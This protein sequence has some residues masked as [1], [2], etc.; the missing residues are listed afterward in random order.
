MRLIDRVLPARAVEARSAV[1]QIYGFQQQVM[2]YGG[3]T[4]PLLARTSMGRQQPVLMSGG[5]EAYAGNGVVFA[6][7]TQRAN[8]FRQARFSW[9]RLGSS[10]RPAAADLFGTAALAPL[11]KCGGLLAQ[12][13][14]DVAT[15]GNAFVVNNA[16]VLSALQPDWVEIVVASDMGGDKPWTNPDARVGGYIYRPP[17][18]QPGE[19]TVFFADEVAHIRPYV[20]PDSRFRGMS[21][22]RPVVQDARSDNQARR[23]VQS[24]YEN[25]ATPNLIFKFP[26]EVEA[27]M[28]R[29]YRQLFLEKHQG[30][31]K[32]FEPAFIG[33]G[34]DPVVLGSSLKDLDQEA[35]AAA[36]HTAICAAA[37]V[38]P[39]LV[40]TLAGLASSTMANYGEAKRWMLDNTLRPL[41][42][43]VAEQLES[44]VQVPAGAQLWADLRSVSALQQDAI[45]DA[46][47][48]QSQAT[49]TRTL[50]DGG[51]DPVSVIDAVTSGDMA[52]LKHT[53]LVSV[54][55]LPP[56]EQDTAGGDSAS[57]GGGQGDG[58]DMPVM[59]PAMN[60]S[61]G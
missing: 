61:A 8:L 59:T 21:Y 37:G 2:A 38:P 39:L 11:D 60:G 12:I 51:F 5:G 52:R 55:L 32:A 40:G 15:A 4:Y 58:E 56:G 57:P 14:L 45:D 31:R 30:A 43:H 54:Q 10:P 3:H 13:E 7:V 26:P 53:G 41:W 29:A 36:V 9:L 48:M 33:G 28:I 1:D 19:A 24:F 44:V 47:A 23:Y 35:T 46:A 6:V 18:V 27:E 25:S 16:G 22:L 20:D 17:D 50:V 34:A 49:T 42:L